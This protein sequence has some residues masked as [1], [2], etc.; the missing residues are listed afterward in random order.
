ME[1]TCRFC[2]SPLEL[3]NYRHVCTM[4][5]KT[6]LT[7]E[8]EKDMQRKAW[9][10]E[11]GK[12]CLEAGDYEA[13]KW[14][15]GSLIPSRPGKDCDTDDAYL[16]LRAATEDFMKTEELAEWER[17]PLEN[18]WDQ[19][20]KDGWMT[21]EMVRYVQRA[22]HER[23]NAYEEKRR[24]DMGIVIF[25]ILALIAAIALCVYI[26]RAPWFVGILRAALL[27]TVGGF[28]VMMFV[29]M[30]V[31]VHDE[32]SGNEYPNYQDTEDRPFHFRN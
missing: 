6:A 15:L 30:I 23:L 22:H 3:V 9:N 13:A 4:C 11:H 29:G 12:E 24:P 21:D 19:V 28:G 1:D 25:G 14:A 5:G 31:D 18:A 17:G 2:G 27:L 26:A 20:R 16:Y 7:E 32:R 10:L 8:E